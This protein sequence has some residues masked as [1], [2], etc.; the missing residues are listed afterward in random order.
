M[1]R[2]LRLDDNQTV[3][4]TRLIHRNEERTRGHDRD[5]VRE[6]PKTVETIHHVT[7]ERLKRQFEE[8]VAARKRR[9]SPRT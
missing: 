7:T 5:V 9:A 3:R 1:I 8:R 6:P 2:P 4:L